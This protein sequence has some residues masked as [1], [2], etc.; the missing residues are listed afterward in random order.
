MIYFSYN[1]LHQFH[2]TFTTFTNRHQPSWEAVNFCNLLADRRYGRLADN[3]FFL[4]LLISF[5]FLRTT[6]IALSLGNELLCVK[7]TETEHKAMIMVS[8]YRFVG[9]LRR[10]HTFG[11]CKEFFMHFI[12]NV[13]TIFFRLIFF[14]RCVHQRK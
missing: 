3:F 7:H 12:N 8:R 2:I 10:S 13:H 9:R 4:P 11:L 5:L 14:S 6:C 1:K